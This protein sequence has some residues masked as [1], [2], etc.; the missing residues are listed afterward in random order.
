MTGAR[1]GFTL[2]ELL[3]VIVIIGILSSSMMLS[4]GAATDMAEASNIVS[5]L[6]GLKTACLLFLLDSMDEVGPGFVPELAMLTRYIDNPARFREGGNYTIERG[7]VDGRWYVGIDLRA[8]NKSD[9]VAKR[10]AGRARSVGLLQS[11][12]L[13][14]FFTA[15]TSE[16]WMV[17]R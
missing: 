10:L 2:V 17:A 13:G 5:D 7:V 15:E 8:A 11:A 1:K 9:G 12:N 14:D 6:Y 16:V 3:I 4:S